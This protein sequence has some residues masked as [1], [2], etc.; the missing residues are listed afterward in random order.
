MIVRVYDKESDIYFKSMVYAVINTGGYEQN[1]VIVPSENGDYFKIIEC[2]DKTDPKIR[3]ENINPV[4]SEG[5]NH[6][7]EWIY[8]YTGNT[9]KN[10]DD[11]SGLLS[12]DIIF[13]A[14]YGFS[15]IYN[16]KPFLIELLNGGTIPVKGYEHLIPDGDEYKLEGWN[17]VE[18]QSDIDFLHTQA[19]GFHDTIIKEL[20][21]TSGCY[22]DEE[23]CMYI[24][25]SSER[26]VT[27]LFNS[28]WCKHIE[29]IF[30]SVTELNLRPTNGADIYGASL[31]IK[32]ETIFFCDAE[33]DGGVNKSYDEIWIESYGLRWRFLE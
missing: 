26:K 12:E 13:Y 11:Y 28:Q 33:Y 5:F 32:D 22:V 20:N 4:T 7:N 18:N 29:L 27:I 21:Y 30:F 1:L 2:I 16:N 14:Y 8:Q 25:D 3:K 24:T 15:W 23:K 31:L 9:D 6:H 19:Y 17:Y 10:L